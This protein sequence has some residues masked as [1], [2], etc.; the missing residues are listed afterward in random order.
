[1]TVMACDDEIIPLQ[2]R[3]KTVGDDVDLQEVYDNEEDRNDRAGSP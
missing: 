3:I 2:E 1:V